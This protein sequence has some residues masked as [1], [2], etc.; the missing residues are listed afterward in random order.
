MAE[1]H[2]PATRD[3]WERARAQAAALRV[4]SSEL[5]G[6]EFA[7]DLHHPPA[8][9]FRVTGSNPAGAV[10]GAGQRPAHTATEFD[11]S[12][13]QLEEA[14]ATRATTCP[15]RSL[16]LRAPKAA[17]K[18]GTGEAITKISGAPARFRIQPGV[19][20]RECEAWTVIDRNSRNAR[21][22]GARYWREG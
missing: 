3:S 4:A 20:L 17:E 10:E 19:V 6:N 13:T 2:N 14:S 12:P 18:I 1:A 22:F 15:K 8:A 7:Y 9:R 11:R 21:V 16:R 5:I